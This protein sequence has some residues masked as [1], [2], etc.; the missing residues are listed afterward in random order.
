MRLPGGDDQRHVAQD[1]LRCVVLRD[2]GGGESATRG[3]ARED[4][5]ERRNEGRVCPPR[6]SQNGAN[7]PA[8]PTGA[9]TADERAPG[10][11]L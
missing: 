8:D 7:A 1:E 9:E 2:V 6:S 5:L 10:S 4:L 11:S 3:V